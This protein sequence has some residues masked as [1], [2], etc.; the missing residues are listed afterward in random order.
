MSPTPRRRRLTWKARPPTANSLAARALEIHPSTFA[1]FRKM[2][3]PLHDI[4]AARAWVAG[5]LA[6]LQMLRTKGP[7]K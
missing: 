3:C 2:G 7:T 1:A 6:T 4:A 5:H